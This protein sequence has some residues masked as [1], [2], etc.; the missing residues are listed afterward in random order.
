MGLPSAVSH[1]AKVTN[2]RISGGIDRWSYDTVAVDSQS[3]QY[4]PVKG[5][6]IPSAH[7]VVPHSI[8]A[9]GDNNNK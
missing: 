8:L 1:Q 4:S 5:N 2:N 7:Q 3:R 6:T 9:N